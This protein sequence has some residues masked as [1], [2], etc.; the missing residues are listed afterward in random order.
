MDCLMDHF[1]RLVEQY[2][3]MMYKIMHTLRIYKNFDHFYSIAL[4]AL[5]E[6][7]E[8]YDGCSSSFS[9]FAYTLIRG[10]LLNELQLEGRYDKHNVPSLM[11]F[12]NQHVYT[13]EY[14]IEEMDAV[15]QYC[16]N[17]TELQKRWVI[18]TFL[19]DRSL[20]DIAA[21][22]HVDKTVVKSWRKSALTKLRKQMNLI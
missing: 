17:L 15:L 9:T 16:E 7:S 20:D 3:P 10:R 5:W 21:I 6:A 13:H 14:S 2:T 11:E 12:N 8:K 4:Q 22:Y 19:Y 18:H 1:E